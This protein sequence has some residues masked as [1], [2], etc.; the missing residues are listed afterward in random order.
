MKKI[1]TKYI[2]TFLRRK[3]MNLILCS[4]NCR[5]QKDG[6]CCLREY[7]KITDVISSPCVY[8]DKRE[9]EKDDKDKRTD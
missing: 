2:Q 5:H 1:S 8:F 9:E 6:Y 4:E 7:G 3:I